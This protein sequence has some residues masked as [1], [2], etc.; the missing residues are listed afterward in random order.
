MKKRIFGILLMGAMVVASMS[1][2]TSC[3]DYDDDINSVKNDVTALRTELASLKTTLANDL[4]T[5]K[6]QLQTAIDAK[7]SAADLTA[8]AGRVATLETKIAAIDNCASKSDV[9]TLATTLATLTGDVTALQNALAAKA[10]STDLEKY[11]LDANLQAAIAN[12][13]LQQ[14]AIATLQTKVQELQT[15]LAAKGNV[16]AV[17]ALQ[18]SLNT[19]TTQ[20]GEEKAKL[21]TATSNISSLQTSMNNLSTDVEKVLADINVLTVLVNKN[22]TS[23]V[24]KPYLYDDGIETAE[25][26]AFVAPYTY[27]IKSGAA[28]AD[29]TW[30]AGK[31]YTA[32]SLYPTSTMYYHFNPS[33]ADLDGFKISF[34]NN[35]AE[36]RGVNDLIMP[37]DENLSNENKTDESGVLGVKIANNKETFDALQKLYWNSGYT[38]GLFVALQA[39]KADTIVNSDYAQV[40]P[41]NLYHLYIA[42]KACGDDAYSHAYNGTS[43]YWTWD[44]VRTA[45]DGIDLDEW[46]SHKIKYDTTDVDLKQYLQI[47]YVDEYTVGTNDH[48]IV[49]QAMLDELGLQYKFKAISYVRQQ[50]ADNTDESIHIKVTEDGLATPQ[51][52][53]AT[54]KV[55]GDN[56]KR[57]AIGREPVVRVTLEDKDGIIYAYGYIKLIISEDV[58]LPAVSAELTMNGPV[59]A[60]CDWPAASL[61]WAQ[62]EADVL[63]EV[64]ISHNDLLAY[65]TSNSSYSG[66]GWSDDYYWLG[67]N[68]QYVKKADGSYVTVYENNKEIGQAIVN[69]WRSGTETLD[70]SVSD[71]KNLIIAEFYENGGIGNFVWKTEPTITTFDPAGAISRIDDAPEIDYDNMTNRWGNIMA[72]APNSYESARTT[73]FRWYIDPTTQGILNAV[74]G[75]VKNGETQKPLNV[76]VRLS[77]NPVLYID[78]TLPAKGIKFAT[79][80]VN[81]DA[82]LNKYWYAADATVVSEGAER[83]LRANV[84]T[85]TTAGAAGDTPLAN[86]DFTFNILSTFVGGTLKSSTDQQFN[87]FADYANGNAYFAFTTPKSAAKDANLNNSNLGITTYKNAKVWTVKGASGI[88]YTL[89][90]TDNSGKPVTDGTQIRIV[91]MVDPSNDYYGT[92]GVQNDQWGNPI[93]GLFNQRASIPVVSLLDGTSNMKEVVTYGT[94]RLAQDI[95]NYAGHAALKA[96]ETF[97]AYVKIILSNDNQYCYQPKLSNGDSF[98]VRFLRPVDVLSGASATGKDAIDGFS[99]AELFNA[100]D[101]TKNMLKLADWRG[102]DFFKLES[103]KYPNLGYVKYYGVKLSVDASDIRTDLALTPGATVSDPSTLIT[104]DKALGASTA[105]TTGVGTPIISDINDAPAS[106]QYFF[107]D[108]KY[109]DEYTVT[110][111]NPDGEGFYKKSSAKM[112]YTEDAPDA[113]IT[114]V[115]GVAG[116]AYVEHKAATAESAEVAGQSAVAAQPAYFKGAPVVTYR[117]N[118]SN[119]QEFNLYLPIYVTYTFGQYIPYTQKVWG[120]ITINETPKGRMK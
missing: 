99:V 77:G 28:T 64:N 53:D 63:N 20:L 97:T 71:I 48:K 61:T 24:Y 88:T 7:A 114:Y 105:A 89:A 119:V 3:K 66:A 2:F 72:S 38:K 100:A 21:A 49:S 29:E 11:A 73:L 94:H 85:P 41:V 27:T 112:N 60:N 80:S 107:F 74:P 12:I 39:A 6:S 36:T 23:L 56:K 102:Y 59:Y 108:I 82:T 52:V 57:G 70:Y 101:P 83:E 15:A 111:T 35:V 22:L 76:S 42:D 103:G 31:R 43:P 44:L 79:I 62:V 86:T 4:S 58:E 13:E 96:N 55:I 95:L 87:H 25:L 30:N 115:A 40:V 69:K 16:E 19:L 18:N 10:N 75:M 54:G 45:A 113:G 26:V 110:Q 90:L 117:N 106:G 84:T 32:K 50:W 98:A 8:L 65:V 5:A 67:N 47:H 33:T 14:Q 17:T 91:K 109:Y 104:L 92:S 46:E 37:L 120:K 116:K 93:Y 1:M 81:S 78:F 34:Y 118:T 51:E 9:T 68:I